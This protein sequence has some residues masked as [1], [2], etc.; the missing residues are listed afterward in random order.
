MQLNFFLPLVLLPIL[1][2]FMHH[3][4]CIFTHTHVCVRVSGFTG[5]RLVLGGWGA[6][7]IK[8]FSRLCEFYVRNLCGYIPLCYH[9]LGEQNEIVLWPV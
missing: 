1:F 5:S 3:C 2:R 6:E 7:T 9:Q 8:I 4:V